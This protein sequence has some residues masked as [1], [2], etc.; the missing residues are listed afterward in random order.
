MKSKYTEVFCF[1]LMRRWE[2]DM[3]LP[4]N[5]VRMSQQRSGLSG[6]KSHFNLKSAMLWPE[7]GNTF[8]IWLILRE[9]VFFVSDDPRLLTSG[10]MGCSYYARAVNPWKIITIWGWHCILIQVILEVTSP[11]KH[12]FCLLWSYQVSI[13]STFM[14][15]RVRKQIF[16]LIY[17]IRIRLKEFPVSCF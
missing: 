13:V 3:M 11:M 7:R 2:S 16:E 8:G 4:R 1:I 5:W 14:L 9:Q 10:L 6:K 12:N 15:K 17:K